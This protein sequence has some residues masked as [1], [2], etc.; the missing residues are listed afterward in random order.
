MLYAESA[1]LITPASATCDEYLLLFTTKK[2]LLLFPIF[3]CGY[4]IFT[5]R[6]S[7]LESTISHTYNNSYLDRTL[8]RSDS[9]LLCMNN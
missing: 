7:K 5:T 3:E 2:Y 8:Y 4:E 1:Y 9:E 6:S